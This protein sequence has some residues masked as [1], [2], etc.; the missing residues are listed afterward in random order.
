MSENKLTY[1][2]KFLT[3]KLSKYPLYSQEHTPTDHVIVSVRFMHLYKTV[4]WWIT[5]YN[6]ETKIAFGYVTWLF[7][8]EWGYISIEELAESSGVVIQD[9]FPPM[10]F[11]TV[12]NTFLSEWGEELL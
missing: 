4:N 11:S 9:Y 2:D 10:K 1:F 3:E 12:K 7:E 5:E 8:D 6:P